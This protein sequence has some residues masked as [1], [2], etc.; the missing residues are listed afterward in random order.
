[1]DWKEKI[2]LAIILSTSPCHGKNYHDLSKY[3]KWWWNVKYDS[4]PNDDIEEAIRDLI[5]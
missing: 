3:K 4:K 2:K 1:M 5:K